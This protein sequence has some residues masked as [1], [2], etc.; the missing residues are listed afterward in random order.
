MVGSVTYSTFLLSAITNRSSMN[1]SEMLLIGSIVLASRQAL[2][3]VK[4]RPCCCCLA[5]CRFAMWLCIRLFISLFVHQ[6]VDAY[7]WKWSYLPSCCHCVAGSTVVIV[8]VVVVV[9]AQD[10]ETTAVPEPKPLPTTSAPVAVVETEATRRLRELRDSLATTL[11]QSEAEE[12]QARERALKAERDQARRLLDAT[13][14]AGAAAGAGASNARV[15]GHLFLHVTVT[16]T[17]TVPFGS[18]LLTCIRSACVITMAMG[19]H[20]WCVVV[21]SGRCS[22]RRH[23]R[24]RCNGA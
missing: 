19:L 10:D 17:V 8:V 23:S 12:K 22:W 24:C 15:T 14:A 9:C 11:R 2:H 5:C 18:D 1:Q 13:L 21:R 4:V 6:S 16:V 20:C 7:C 3:F